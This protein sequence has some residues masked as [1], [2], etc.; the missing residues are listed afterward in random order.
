MT[1]LQFCWELTR[2][3]LKSIWFLWPLMVLG[4]F[5]IAV[6]LSDLITY[7]GRHHHGFYQG[8]SKYSAR[9]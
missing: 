1:D 4:A 3:M 6:L 2:Q 9:R 7:I 5:G 8:R